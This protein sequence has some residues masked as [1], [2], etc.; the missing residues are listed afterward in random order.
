MGRPHWC[1]LQV[2]AHHDDRTRRVVDALA[3][4][5]LAEA[6]LL[7]LDHV[8]QRLQRAVA[9]IRA[10]AATATC[11]VEERV[12]RLLK[13]ALLVADDHF[14]RVEVEELLQSV[15]AV[16][17]AAVEIVQVGVAKLPLSSSTSGRR[18]G[19]ITGMTSRT[20]H[21]G[22]LSESRRASTF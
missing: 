6:T 12:D 5:V 14:G 13:H 7:A 11:V 16:D 19:G 2:R 22:L 18:S 9:S 21:S 17:D 20:I 15:V 10:R 3:E 1:N 4:Q 8:R